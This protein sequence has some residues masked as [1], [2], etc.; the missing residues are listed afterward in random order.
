VEGAEPAIGP[1][2]SE[3][4]QGFGLGGGRESKGGQIRQAPSLFDLGKDGVLQFLL[5]ALC[6]GFLALRLLQVRSGEHRLEALGA[7]PRLRGVGFVHDHGETFTGQLADLV[8]DDGELLQGGHND[9]FALFQGLLELARSGI[10]VFYHPQSLLELAHRVLKLAVQHAPV[11]YDHDGIKN[12]LV[13]RIMESSQL[14]GEPGDSEALS[15]AGRV[16]HQV[17][18]PDAMLPGMGH[19]AAHRIQLLVAREDEG[20]LAGLAAFRILLLH[21]VNELPH[22]LQQAVT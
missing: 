21:L 16:L 19:Q 4:L 8:G 6:L 13:L 3:K 10:D 5:R 12:P 20:A 9:G 14:M 17:A 22:Q 1:P 15:T 7:L 18:L 11:R 2:G